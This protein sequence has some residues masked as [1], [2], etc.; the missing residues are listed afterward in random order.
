M[1]G[2]VKAGLQE[3]GERIDMGFFT[4]ETGC[5]MIKI[6]LTAQPTRRALNVSVLAF[7]STLSDTV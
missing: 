7:L 3:V 2:N 5:K 4:P 1:V 6:R